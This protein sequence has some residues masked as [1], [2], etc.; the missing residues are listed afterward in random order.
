MDINSP[1]YCGADLSLRRE[2]AH[3]LE[4][5]EHKRDISKPSFR[6]TERG[7]LKFEINFTLSL[8]SDPPS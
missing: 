5:R 3:G 7:G 4:H 1:E 8:Y 6:R 2:D